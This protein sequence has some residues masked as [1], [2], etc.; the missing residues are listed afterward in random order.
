MVPPKGDDLLSITL[1]RTPIRVSR[2]PCARSRTGPF[3]SADGVRLVDASGEVWIDFLS[4]DGSLNYGHREPTLRRALTDH[5]RLGART[6]QAGVE[7]GARERFVRRFEQHVLEHRGLDYRL[8]FTGSR[9][10][11]AMAESV[12]LARRL[13]GRKTILAFD[14]TSDGDAPGRRT[15]P[16]PYTG[17]PDVLPIPFD[18]AE[19]VIRE[20]IERACGTR[21]DDPRSPAAIVVECTRG[22]GNLERVSSAWLRTV[23]R[24]AR[25]RGALLVVDETL[26]GC[27]RCGDFFAFERSGI[28]PDIVLLSG[29]VS[30][31]G[32]PLSVLLVHSAFERSVT[33]RTS[34]LVRGT[35]HAFV[36]A[37]AALERF[38]SDAALAR[39]VAL[40]AA[41]AHHALQAI[42]AVAG[43]RTTGTGLVQGVEFEDAGT[44]TSAVARCRRDGLLVAPC[45]P[46]RRVLKVMP[47]LTVSGADLAAGLEVLRGAIV[48]TLLV[49]SSP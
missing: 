1:A 20:R 48:K 36:T 32:L 11:E 41:L 45:G 25:R 5:V 8:R 26:T 17:V 34:D 21:P 42:A 33:D 27:G 43:L 49:G 31:Y 24:L 6:R 46:R 7:R 38:W 23:A 10:T 47:A 13:T 14:D 28:V 22:A 9:S 44:C 40:K 30:G 2:T 29:S 4:G 12:R 37:T 35:Q 3:E 18:V 15:A 39:D 16:R 19:E